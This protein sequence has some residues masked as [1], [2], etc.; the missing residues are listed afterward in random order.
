MPLGQPE[1]WTHAAQQASI[2][3]DVAKSSPAVAYLGASVFGMPI[4]DLVSIATLIYVVLQTIL[5]IPRFA[6]WYRSWR[7][8]RC[9]SIPASSPPA[10]PQS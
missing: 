3:L 8:K 2:N 9:P 5:L 1:T 10:P 7:A 6:E 4:P